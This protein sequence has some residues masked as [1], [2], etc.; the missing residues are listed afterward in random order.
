MTYTMVARSTWQM[1]KD[2]VEKEKKKRISWAARFM[3]VKESFFQRTSWSYADHSSQRGKHEMDS[4]KLIATN[5]VGSVMLS[6]DAH[7]TY[8]PRI[9]QS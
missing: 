1:A 5:K 4:F 3:I 9:P 7:M 8:F 6:V 2:S